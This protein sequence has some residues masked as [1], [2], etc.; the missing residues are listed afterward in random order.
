MPFQV[1]PFKAN[2]GGARPPA[3]KRHHVHAVPAKA[4]YEIRFPRVEG[5]RQ[6]IRNRLAIDWSS[7]PTITLD[8]MKIPPEVR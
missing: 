1:V 2:P 3:P 6:A 4:A 5:Y 7:V 8:P